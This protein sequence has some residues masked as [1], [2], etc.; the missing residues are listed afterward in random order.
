MFLKAKLLIENNPTSSFLLRFLLTFYRFLCFH[1]NKLDPLFKP[2]VVSLLEV[3][4]A[5]D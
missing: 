2:L 4:L 3:L 5:L 1:N